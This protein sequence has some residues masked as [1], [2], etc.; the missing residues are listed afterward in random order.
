MS[1][2]PKKPRTRRGSQSKLAGEG[3]ADESDVTA[4]LGLFERHRA[5]H[6]VRAGQRR[7]A[8]KSGTK[9]GT[10]PDFVPDFSYTRIKDVACF[11]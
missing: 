3:A 9:S 5:G 8:V 2:V 4:V 11:R 6:F 10:V 1:G 7:G